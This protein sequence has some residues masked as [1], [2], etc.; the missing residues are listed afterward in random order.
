LERAARR[1]KAHHRV[2]VD[3]QVWEWIT[4]G[5]ENFSGLVTSLLESYVRR[6]SAADGNAG[7]KISVDITVDHA[8]WT[9]ASRL[10]R[11]QGRSLSHVLRDQLQEHLRK[12]RKRRSA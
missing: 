1:K 6:T 5:G 8:L 4:R 7:E 9:E 2:H 11:T 10:A 12:S 3:R